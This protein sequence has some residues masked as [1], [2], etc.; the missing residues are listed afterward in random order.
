MSSLSPVRKPQPLIK[1]Q[2]IIFRISSLG[3]NE[4]EEIGVEEEGKKEEERGGRMVGWD[5][6]E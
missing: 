1:Y 5:E 6:M 2:Y 4:V 3:S